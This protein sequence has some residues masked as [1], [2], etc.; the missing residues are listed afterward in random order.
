MVWNHRFDAAREIAGSL[1]REGLP[2]GPVQDL[3]SAVS[4]ADL[5]SWCPTGKSA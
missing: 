4:Q 3:E 2:A 5:V 1:Q